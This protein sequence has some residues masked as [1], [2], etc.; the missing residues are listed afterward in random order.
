MTKQ[1]TKVKYDKLINLEK[2]LSFLSDFLHNADE[3]IRTAYFKIASKGYLKKY[4]KAYLKGRP[5]ITIEENIFPLERQLYLLLNCSKRAKEIENLASMF[6][7]KGIPAISYLKKLKNPVLFPFIK[8]NTQYLKAYESANDLLNSKEIIGDNSV[9]KLLKCDKSEV[10]SFVGLNQETCYEIIKNVH[11]PREMEF[12][13]PIFYAKSKLQKAEGKIEN[14]YSLF[15]SIVNKIYER[16]A[17]FEIKSK[18]KIENWFLDIDLLKLVFRYITILPTYNDI[19][20]YVG[21][22]KEYLINLNSSI[23]STSYG[24]FYFCKDK[25]KVK[26]DVLEFITFVN[27]DYSKEIDI[28]EKEFLSVN[29][30]SANK[31]LRFIKNDFCKNQEV[32]ND[33]FGDLYAGFKGKSLLKKE[34]ANLQYTIVDLIGDFKGKPVPVTYRVK[35]VHQPRGGLIRLESFNK[36]HSGYPVFKGNVNVHP[37]L[38]GLA[39]DYLTRFMI[40]KNVDTSFKISIVGATLLRQLDTVLLELM[41]NIKGL[42]DL[43]IRCALK[44]VSFD[45]VF[46]AGASAYKELDMDLINE[47]TISF[48]RQ[49]VKNS[50]DYF[51]NLEPIKH[52]GFRFEG[53]YTKYINAGDGDFL[54]EHYLIDLKTSIKEPSSRDTL[55][56]L[57]Y[58]LLGKNSGKSEFKNITHIGIYNPVL[59]NAYTLKVSDI[60]KQIF[61]DIARYVVGI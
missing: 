5:T 7:A 33:Y 32:Y 59:C 25:N 36:I 20:E 1:E 60:N 26:K 14:I 27:K 13:E 43:S 15:T 45:V 22:N 55:Q 11:A 37:S 46:R 6:R 30:K 3:I 29:L 52:V 19:K 8:N 21:R 48:I 35:Q 39:V 61:D 42:D 38:V 24:R 12:S 31:S 51:L 50:L 16:F 18:I 4:E 58:Y 34:Q 23:A 56:I 41:P 17:L 28:F 9:L 44:L 49:L 40:T 54:T 2:D 10:K 57:V 53:G 47:D